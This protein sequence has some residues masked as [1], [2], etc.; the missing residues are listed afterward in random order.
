M[1]ILYTTPKTKRHLGEF[2]SGQYRWLEGKLQELASGRQW[3]TSWG[4]RGRLSTEGVPKKVD[5]I[6]ED[7]LRWNR[8]EGRRWQIRI[9]SGVEREM[10]TGDVI[11][12]SLFLRLVFYVCWVSLHVCVPCVPGALG[13]KGH[14]ILWNWDY[15]WSDVWVLGFEPGLSERVASV[16][17]CWAV[18]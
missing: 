6:R 3:F 5:M 17:N 12:A 11:P 18:S 2:T 14:W 10:V 9:L 7:G 13:S 8:V 1:R 4:T 15:R 16:L